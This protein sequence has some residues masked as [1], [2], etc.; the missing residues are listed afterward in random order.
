MQD[1]TTKLQTIVLLRHVRKTQR[2]ER[3]RNIKCCRSIENS[4]GQTQNC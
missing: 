4:Y 2:G 1:N 3:H